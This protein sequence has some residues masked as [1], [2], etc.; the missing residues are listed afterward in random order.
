VVHHHRGFGG[1]DGSTP[2]CGVWIHQ[3]IHQNSHNDTDFYFDKKGHII[4][5]THFFQRSSPFS[6]KSVFFFPIASVFTQ[7]KSENEKLQ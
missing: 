1:F 6:L 7:G 2:S 5:P 3:S 4:S